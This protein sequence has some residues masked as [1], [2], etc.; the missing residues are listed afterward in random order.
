MGQPQWDIPSAPF[1]E[2]RDLPR[3]APR[4]PMLPRFGAARPPRARRLCVFVLFVERAG[5]AE[6][7]ST[8]EIAESSLRVLRVLGASAFSFSLSREPGTQ[9]RGAPPRSQ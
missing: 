3:R 1:L 6:A 5:N 2:L 4:R 7:R 9:R 8:A